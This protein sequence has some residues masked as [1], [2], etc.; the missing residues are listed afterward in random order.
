MSVEKVNK[1]K[2]DK[3][4]RK[5]NLEKER[6][7]KLLIRIG[8]WAAGAVI[9]V[10]LVV[11]LGLTAKNSYNNYQASKPDYSSDSL[12]ISDMTGILDETAADE[13]VDTEETAEDGTDESAESDGDTTGDESAS[14][15]SEAE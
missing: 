15:E 2:E 6:K 7:K 10:A 8:G 5:A 1:Y 4:N 11:M 13:E 14:G 12:V 3:K 9:V